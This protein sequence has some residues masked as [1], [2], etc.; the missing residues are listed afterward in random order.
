MLQY[1][2]A[3]WNSTLKNLSQLWPFHK[4]REM[5]KQTE[6]EGVMKSYFSFF[7]A[8]FLTFASGVPMAAISF[9]VV[10]V[11]TE[12]AIK[13]RATHAETAPTSR[14]HLG[15]FSAEHLTF[16]KS[17]IVVTLRGIF[18]ES[19]EAGN[20]HAYQ[21]N[22]VDGGCRR[23]RVYGMTSLPPVA[24][25]LRKEEVVTGKHRTGAALEIWL[26]FTITPKVFGKMG[27]LVWEQCFL[28]WL[29]QI[30]QQKV[31]WFFES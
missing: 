5:K 15:E 20:R 7:L 27:F 10:I 2:V 1:A 25:T 9:Y 26:S 3:L 28:I 21:I 16:F 13:G 19:A 12:Q 24:H 18:D 6:Q 30:K 8:P 11:K 4:K 17:E 14:R 23:N 22:D 31:S 29:E